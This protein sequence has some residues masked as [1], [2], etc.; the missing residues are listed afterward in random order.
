MDQYAS[1][2]YITIAIVILIGTIFST[3]LL[4]LQV[5]NKSYELS[6]ESNTRRLEIIYPTRGL[7]YDRN[8][9]LIVHN[10]PTYDLKI[11]PYELES[12][13]TNALCAILGIEKK[14]LLK[15]IHRVKT[16]SSARREPFIKQISPEVFGE[17]K[18][19][20]YKFP[21]FYFTQ[22][23]FRKYEMET[24]AHLLGYLGEV[25]SA[26][27]KK[28]R[29]YELGDYYG[30]SGVE[31]TYEPFLRGE[32]GVRYRTIDVRGREVGSYKEGRYDKDAIPGKDIALTIDID[33]Q[34]Y[35]EKLMDGYKGSIVAIE[36][37]TGEV[38][39]FISAPGY[40]PSLLIGRERE[41]NFHLLDND[42][43]KPL[44]NN[45]IQA[46]YPPGST[47]KTI[48]GLIGMQEG[49]IS[50]RSSFGC[51]N[52]YYYTRYKK[53]GC[54]YHKTPLIF[55]PAL[56]TSCNSY[57]CN[58]YKRILEDKDYE[59]VEIAYANWR[60]HATTF[61]LANNLGI[62]LPYE[63]NGFIPLPDYY[64]RFYGKGYWRANTIIS[65]AIGQGEILATPLQIAN[66][67]AIIAN[68][69][70]YY[71]PHV[72][73]YIEGYDTINAQFTTP[74]TV[75]V[76]TSYFKYIIDGMDAAINGDDGSGK[77]ARL[78]DIT[79]CGK[80]GTAENPHGLEH[81]VFMAFAPKEDP[82]IAISV[83][84]EHGEWGA[85][86]AAPI[87]G[88]MVEKYLTDTISPYRRWIEKRMLEGDLISKT[89]ETTD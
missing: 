54:H 77:L 20:Q 79:L 57:F 26:E 74:R 11:A 56:E 71:T 80:T 88:L 23:T 22:R 4:F 40:N 72:V 55:I 48:N 83:Y 17:L 70:Y 2:K 15:A 45:A 53:V 65:N 43:L 14:F 81:S 32:K 12:F 28:D 78:I 87:A 69:G 82:E 38:L 85:T 49:V 6:A 31:R 62:D 34:L 7:I 46:Q 33:L 51:A 42:T 47:F 61:G 52:G 16:V 39:A 68:K 86:Y 25:D 10:Q 60:Q 58:T 24:S 13:D 73:K 76:D 44:Y 35:G 41:G 9:Q 59:S 30:V 37:T 89:D 29:Y 64:N 21:G 50:Y 67:A 63:K 84:V 36:P 19:N 66:L 75:S 5:I 3:K 18:E 1:R 27:I 8:G